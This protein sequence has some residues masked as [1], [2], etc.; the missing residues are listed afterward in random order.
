MGEFI[1]KTLAI[2]IIAVVAIL[3]FKAGHWFGSDYESVIYN[4]ETSQDNTLVA[5]DTKTTAIK[6][7]SY[8]LGMGSNNF[9]IAVPS[10]DDDGYPDL[11][12]STS[13]ISFDY[14]AQKNGLFGIQT[15]Y[16]LCITGKDNNKEFVS[17][18]KFYLNDGTPLRSVNEHYSFNGNSAILTSVTGQEQHVNAFIPYVAIEKFN[19][20]GI[21]QIMNDIFGWK[22]RF[23]IDLYMKNPI[24]NSYSLMYTSGLNT[25]KVRF[26]SE[27]ESQYKEYHN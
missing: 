26:P 10:Q 25:F 17:V 15:R 24:E 14:K 3:A 6:D 7:N 9:I 16:N 8:H 27:Y 20:T 22:L 19:N 2:L 21:N 23:R 4:V 13:N 11:E 18:M 5:H 1:F 12:I